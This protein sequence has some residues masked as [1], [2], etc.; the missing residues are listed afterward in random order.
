MKQV[1]DTRFLVE[2]FYSRDKNVTKK[3]KAKL[4]EL[5]RKG[6][7][8]LPTIV[9]SEI[10]K[11]TCARRGREEAKIRYASLLRSGLVIKDLDPDVAERAG[12]LKC[13]Y[14]DVPMGDC[15]IAAIAIISGAS[16]LSDDPHFDTMKEVKR[17]WI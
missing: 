4:K 6:D 16:V 14:D 8:I 10:V 1:I 7:G 11:I 3:T 5:R 2:H 13:K 17:V 15:I 9:T 12:I